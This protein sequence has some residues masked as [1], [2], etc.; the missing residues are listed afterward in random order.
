MIRRPPRSTLFPYTTLFRSR[1]AVRG[2]G[3]ADGGERRRGARL[4]DALVQD[5][6]LLGL[7]VRQHQ[8]AVDR[9][10]ALAGRVVDLLAGEERI[11]AERAGL[12]R[13]SEERRVGKECRS[14]WSPYH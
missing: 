5:H 7:L 12:V 2:V 13:R 14:R 8:L 11:E 4:V 3:G 6:A 10:V 1:L 9:S